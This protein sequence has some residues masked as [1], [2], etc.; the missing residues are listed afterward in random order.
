MSGT[1]SEG[2]ISGGEKS[3]EEER[4]KEE[5]S[6][7]LEKRK[8]GKKSTIK[9]KTPGRERGEGN[10]LV[11]TE[12][13]FKE[14]REKICGLL[15]DMKRQRAGGGAASRRRYKNNNEME[16]VRRIRERRK[17]ECLGKQESTGNQ[18]G[19]NDE[20]RKGK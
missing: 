20:N 15:E 4:K 14:L 12:A 13:M 17:R 9:R 8:N 16:G 1:S 2:I 19:E 10:L 5:G 3:A 18:Q 11:S 7:K 6:E